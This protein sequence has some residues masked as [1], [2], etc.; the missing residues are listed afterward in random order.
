[1]GRSK[2]LWIAECEEVAQAYID[3]DIS[4]GEFRTRMHRLGYVDSEIDN[5]IDA[6]NEDRN[7]R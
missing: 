4:S 7:G 1:M 5:E 3:R 2:D 6:L